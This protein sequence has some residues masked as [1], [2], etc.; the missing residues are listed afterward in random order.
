MRTI[1]H[2]QFPRVACL[3]ILMLGI[4]LA[5]TA[6]RA[7]IEFVVTGVDETLRENILRHNDVVRLGRSELL[8]DRELDSILEH[9]L[10]LT[11]IALQP[12]GYY[13]P[14]VTGRYR[15]KSDREPVI[16]LAVEPGPPIIIS[17]VHLTLTGPGA[18]RRA[19]KTWRSDFPLKKGGRLIQVEWDMEK[20]RVSDLAGAA[21]YLELSFPE[22]EIAID[23]V[24]NTAE[25][26]LT[27]DTGPRFIIGDIDF[28][29]HVLQPG[30]VEYIPRF[31]KG[32]PYSARLMDDF[33]LDLWRSGYFTDVEVIENRDT[34]ASPPVVNLEVRLETR[35]RNSYQGALGFGTDTGI[36]LQASWSKRPFSQRGDRIEV[37]IGW[38]EINQEFAIR[39]NYR[40]PL[41]RRPH[42]FWVAD[43]TIRYENQDLELSS[44][45]NEEN[46]IKIANGNVDERHVKFGWLKIFNYRAGEKQMFVQPFGQY[47]N[48]VRDYDLA[49]TGSVPIDFRDQQELSGLLRGTDNAFSFGVDL[50]IVAVSGSAF[51]SHGMHDRAWIFAA[52]RN[53]GSEVDFLQAYISTR[54][55][56]LLGKRFKLLTRAEIGYTDAKVDAFSIDVEGQPLALSITQLPNFYRFKAGGSASV[57]G[58]SFE[59]L[60]NN[61]VGSNNIVT[62]SVEFEYRLTER[63]SVAAFADIGNAF[64]DWSAPELKLGLGVGV[65]WYS[66]AG[67]IRVDIAQAQDFPDRSLRIHLTIGTPLL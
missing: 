53:L 51:E 49:G 44:G 30:I 3:F 48:S 20:Q 29:E 59:E 26:T 41:P 25:L 10:L 7:E 43:A 56:F 15:R 47:L 63:W 17:A 60:S 61:N 19:L 5:S 66:I 2:N 6:S 31:Q 16:E 35:T 67:P 27:V 65:R 64:N 52:D 36:R 40:L 22:H 55:T 18:D 1:G 57:R 50:N 39:G 24:E 42:E 33:R 32:D 37:G 28:G 11:R 23:L 8:S 62:G 58:Y 14:N 54:R 4:M 45:G 46:F 34:D 9:S 21:G 12:Y 38:Q 13:H